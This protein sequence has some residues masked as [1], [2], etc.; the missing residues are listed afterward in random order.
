MATFQHVI[1]LAET[2]FSCAT[3]PWLFM[4]LEGPVDQRSWRVFRMIPWIQGFPSPSLLSTQPP[5][6]GFLRLLGGWKKNKSM[7]QPSGGYI[8]LG[9]GFRY[10]LFSSLFGE[11]IPF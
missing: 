5:C 8:V 6:I 9:G 10:V 1:F 2:E 11:M 3:F 7:F 4:F